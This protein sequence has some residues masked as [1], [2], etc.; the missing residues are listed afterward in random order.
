[1]SAGVDKKKRNKGEL[2]VK[3]YRFVTLEKKE[4]FA[5]WK[6]FGKREFRAPGE[7]MLLGVA[8]ARSP[9]EG[10]PDDAGDVGGGKRDRT[11]KKKGEPGPGKGEGPVGEQRRG[12]AW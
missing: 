2:L 5:C 12:A 9:G 8:F 6:K 7:A 4:R 10:G 3:D 1:L 11:R